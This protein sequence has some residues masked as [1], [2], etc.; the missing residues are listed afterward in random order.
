MTNIKEQL[1]K[2]FADLNSEMLERQLAWKSGVCKAMSEL[3]QANKATWMEATG[4]DERAYMMRPIQEKEQ[5]LFE[6][7][8]ICGGKTVYNN[9]R[10]P[11]YIEKNVK[12]LI[13]N[14]DATIIN[15]LEKIGVTELPDFELEH[16]SDGVYGR[17]LIA[18]HN[19]TIKVI[20]AGGYN[21]Q[22]LHTRTLV[23]VK[24]AA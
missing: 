12:K 2:A 5:L 9:I 4:K 18:G 6:L 21:I 3:R 19:V 24:E 22:R 13:E 20:V 8:E 15:A 17:F 7:W 16:K 14:R 10:N 1:S 23:N 11:N